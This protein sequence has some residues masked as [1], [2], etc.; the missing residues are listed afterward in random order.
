[1]RVRPVGE[2]WVTVAVEVVW[3][4]AVEF[5]WL[6]VMVTVKEPGAAKVCSPRMVMVPSLATWM[7]PLS[8]ALVPSPQVMVAVSSWRLMGVVAEVMVAMVPSN[9][10]P[11]MELTAT[12]VRVRAEMGVSTGALEL[13]L[14]E[15][16]LLGEGVLVPWPEERGEPERRVRDSRDSRRAWVERARVR[17]RRREDL[18]DCIE[19]LLGKRGT[20]LHATVSVLLRM[21]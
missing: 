14:E 17:V 18:E 13:A 1:L 3:V 16:P 7:L 8:S 20:K 2:F 4:V 9:W 6:S 15:G 11:V 10:T 21:I 12:P 5:F 19:R